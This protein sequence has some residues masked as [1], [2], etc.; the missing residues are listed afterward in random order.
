MNDF[1]VTTAVKENFIT[2]EIVELEKIKPNQHVTG[3]TKVELFDSNGLTERT[4]S[5]N[6]VAQPMTEW[7]RE[8]MRL[9]FFNYS[10]S[11]DGIYGSNNET[12][13]LLDYDSVFERQ[14][15]LHPLTYLCL[16][17]FEGEEKPSTERQMKGNVVGF[18]NRYGS[19]AGS[20]TMQG[21]IN[22]NDSYAEK[23]HQHFVFD[24]PTHAG[25]GTFSSVYFN[26]DEIYNEYGKTTTLTNINEMDLSSLSYDNYTYVECMKK[27]G[28][29]YYI[30]F[31]NNDSVRH[32]CECSL[33][34]DTGELIIESSVSISG[35]TYNSCYDITK[36]SDAYIISDYDNHF[37]VFN[38]DGTPANGK[39]SDWEYISQTTT[40]NFFKL[41]KTD[42]YYTYENNGKGILYINDSLYISGIRCKEN[43]TDTKYQSCLRKY[44]Y[45]TGEIISDKLVLNAGYTVTDIHYDSSLD[46]IVLGAYSNLFWID[47]N[48]LSYT[49][50]LPIQCN[51]P[52]SGGAYVDENTYIHGAY[53]SITG[54][55]K[56]YLKKVK[57]GA[58]GTRNLLPSPVT[59]TSQNTMKITY[60]FYF[61]DIEW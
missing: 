50:D 21:T 49:T 34:I 23:N 60:D 38:L 10:Y 41:L 9:S 22:V 4:V 56:M 16:T 55:R 48:T 43:S 7:Q 2:G 53:T 18:A 39:Y 24:F 54:G 14:M 31:K 29:K 15:R 8:L 61:E 42:E 44:D 3:R 25:N 40:S 12:A 46:S 17:D 27:Q 59:K 6:F 32:I 5:E 35:I 45:T 1:K 30:V 37:Y 20:S 19:Y 28:D 11:Q 47:K 13:S 51:M 58:I 26:C 33:D 52:T 57:L 36:T